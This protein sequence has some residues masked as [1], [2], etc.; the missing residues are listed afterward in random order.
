MDNLTKKRR[1]LVSVGVPTYNRPAGLRRTIECITTQTYRNLE[2][3]ISDNASPN[4]EVE[5]VVREF[6]QRDP[7][8]QYY[9]QN[10][11]KGASFNFKFVLK[12]ARGEYF[13]WAA[14]DDE[15]ENFYIEKLVSLLEKPSM[16]RFIAANF[17]AQYMDENSTR[18]EYFP[19]GAHF[20]DFQS[21]KVRER[22][23][24]ILA[25]NYGNLIYSLYRKEILDQQELVFAENEIPFLLQIAEKGNWRVLPEIGFL[26]KTVP[27][28]YRQARW[29][30][31]GG[32]LDRSLKS[33]WLSLRNT[34]KYHRIALDNIKT[35]IDTLNLSIR[36]QLSLK[37]W[38]GY[39]IWKHW[40]FL[41]I[42]FKLRQF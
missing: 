32:F 4:P 26:K 41:L 15:W 5:R 11:N 2:I 1:P 31:E 38:A 37:S 12:N 24:H 3:I 40:F 33:T 14:D 8:I 9:R 20:Y 36:D 21:N 23:K 7:R 16:K 6:R 22:I 19:E 17:E 39:L 35:A 18:F 28:T 34:T 10:E 13:M 27:S 42:G 29:E 25:H 30:M